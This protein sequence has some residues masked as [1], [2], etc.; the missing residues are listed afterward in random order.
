[1]S[2]LLVATAVL[3]LLAGAAQG[4]VF[5]LDLIS[6]P[7]VFHGP[8]IYQ[9][10]NFKT[11]GSG[12]IDPFLTVKDADDPQVWGY[13]NDAAAHESD[14]VEEVDTHSLTLDMV[15][16]VPGS[17]RDFRVFLLDNNQEGGSSQ[18]NMTQ[19]E[20]YT[21]DDD[22]DIILLTTLQ[23][24]GTLV[25]SLDDP[26]GGSPTDDGTVLID[27]NPPGSG[28]ADVLLF[29]PDDLFTVFSGGESKTNVYLYSEFTLNNDG[30]EEW[31]VISG[32]PVPDVPGGGEPPPIVPAPQTSVL[33]A[34][35]LTGLLTSKKRR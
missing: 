22:P 32:V 27:A 11:T 29:V 3:V 5:T 34:L 31:A 28:N 19:L 35:G 16:K 33:L 14:D 30:F 15:P 10:T 24:T 2:K 7:I 1:M 17:T 21:V 4:G 9:E 6:N 18:I 13:N 20:I 23:A 26:A 25:Y 8:V 12:V